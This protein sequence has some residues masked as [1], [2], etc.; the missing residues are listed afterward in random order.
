MMPQ[1]ELDDAIDRDERFV[2]VSFLGDVE[3]ME[4]RHVL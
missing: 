4:G 1:S 2:E 3:H